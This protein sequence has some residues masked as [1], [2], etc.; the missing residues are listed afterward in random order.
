[1]LCTIHEVG[2]YNHTNLYGNVCVDCRS[3]EHNPSAV[4]PWI[5]FGSVKETLAKNV[6]TALCVVQ[7]KFLH[8]LIVDVIQ[9]GTWKLCKCFATSCFYLDVAC[10]PGSTAFL[11]SCSPSFTSLQCHG[12]CS[13]MLQQYLL[14]IDVMATNLFQR[15]I[16]ARQGIKPL[17][18]QPLSLPYPKSMS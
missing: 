2:C 17:S 11:V 6:Q 9:Y 1:M 3:N 8:M 18:L 5:Q 16:S 7:L 15:Y 13:P 4:K 10:L 12:L 14:H